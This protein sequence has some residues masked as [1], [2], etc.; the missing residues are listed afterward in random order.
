MKQERRN[1]SLWN[2]FSMMFKIGVLGFGG[3]NALIPLLHQ[4][5]VEEYGAV[6][7]TEFDEDVLIA[8]V[9]PGAL[10][11]EIAGGI[12]HRVAGWKGT[13]I[14]AIGMAAPGVI[15]T[16]L[17]LSVVSALD[18]R[19]ISQIHFLTVGIMAFIC[20]L[21]T[22]YV[23]E[24]FKKHKS[25]GNTNRLGL[26]IVIGC[27][28][29]LTCGKNIYRLFGIARK[30]FFGL[31]TIHIFVLAFFVIFFTYG[32]NSV[33]RK[34]LAICC[35]LIYILCAGQFKLI[36]N[37]RVFWITKMLMLGICIFELG[38]QICT[39]RLQRKSFG[40]EKFKDIFILILAVCV[41]ALIAFPLSPEIQAFA[42]RGL[43]STVI[44]FGGG[45][46]YLTVADGLFVETG[47]VKEL[48]FYGSL[49][50]VVNVLPGSVLCK[51]LSGVGFIFGKNETGTLTGGILVALLG[52]TCS[53]AASV[54]VFLLIHVFYEDV[55]ELDAFVG[56]RK[57]IRTIVTGLMLTVMCSLIYVAKQTAEGATGWVCV[58]IMMFIY[59]I[60]VWLKQKKQYS[61]IKL[62][63]VAVILSLAWCNLSVWR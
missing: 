21:L 16:V 61:N 25:M 14:G 5:V 45:D 35:C 3:G 37:Q 63:A 22:E 53:V 13:M 39:S 56:V 49:V 2:L 27:V 48:D 28:F 1:V 58:G 38:K 44:S 10:P 52:F 19:I 54:G 33:V 9:T 29:L 8:S 34:I 57:W 50:P 24:T 46:A 12:G 51:T 4:K 26:F 47:M 43:F 62:I 32:K 11:V 15:L 40:N 59:A 7:E 42:G 6:N 18:Q 30:P 31:S 20:V 17:I 41:V 23:K 36:D 60:G 55:K